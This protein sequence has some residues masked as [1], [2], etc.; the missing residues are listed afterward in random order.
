MNNRLEVRISNYL[1]FTNVRDLYKVFLG[2]FVI[3]FLSVLP[4]I[5]AIVE[6]NLEALYKGHLLMKEIVL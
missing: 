6:G 4:I 1:Q 3:V 5:I 2:Y